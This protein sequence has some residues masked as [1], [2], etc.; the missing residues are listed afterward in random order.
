MIELRYL[1][2]LVALRDCG[3]LIDAAE[4]VHLTQSALSL[5]HI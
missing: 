5:I 3:T 2:T 4:Q 1:R